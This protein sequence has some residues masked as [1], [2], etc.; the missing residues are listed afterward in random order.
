MADDEADRDYIRR[1][2]Y[3]YNG[4]IEKDKT[5]CILTKYVHGRLAFVTTKMDNGDK[6]FIEAATKYFN[7]TIEKHQKIV[8]DCRFLADHITAV[9][10]DIPR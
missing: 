2:I 1:A 9:V 8:D 5:E 6:I 4:K 3:C 7:D 10:N